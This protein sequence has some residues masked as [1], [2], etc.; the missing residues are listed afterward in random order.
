M[1]RQESPRSA[2]VNV[3]GVDH[4]AGSKGFIKPA[5]SHSLSNFADSLALSTHTCPFPALPLPHLF[6]FE[7]RTVL[8]ES[9]PVRILHP[10]DSSVQ[11]DQSPERVIC[12]LAPVARPAEQDAVRDVVGP[13]LRPRLNV[14]ELHE[15]TFEHTPAAR[16]DNQPHTALRFD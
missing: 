11:P 1:F 5:V 6:G 13:A 16:A 3:R 7:P 2:G 4:V 8:G 9:G 10:S 15:L 12:A 14:V